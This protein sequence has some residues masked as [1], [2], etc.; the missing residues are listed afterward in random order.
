MLYF[1]KNDAKRLSYQDQLAKLDPEDLVYLDE[2]GFDSTLHNPYGRAPRGQKITG[3]VSGKFR[4]RV[5]MIS[6]YCENKFLAPMTFDGYCNT[7]VF[8]TWLE[9][10]LLPEL[11]KGQT[12]VMDN[13]SFHKSAKTKSLIESTGCNILFLPPY[14][15]D[16][17][18]IEH[19]WGTLKNKIRNI[20]KPGK[21]IMTAIRKAFVVPNKI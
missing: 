12:V 15:P 11:K 13:A 5:S 14:S 17:N 2:S 6:A 19:A 3:H 8:N 7:L 10:M 9:K 21:K 1:E 18:P 4:Q 20:H 16:Y